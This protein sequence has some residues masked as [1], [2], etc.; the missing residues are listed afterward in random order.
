MSLFDRKFWIISAHAIII[1]LAWFSPLLF[2]WLVILAAMILYY[3]QILIIG[4]CVLTKWQFN[5]KTREETFY[6]YVLAKVGINYQNKYLGD[7]VLPWI[8]LGFAI[9]WQ[10]VLNHTPLI[11]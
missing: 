2:S 1:V 4:D 5:R 11:H 3:L 7:L 8:I 10:I 6:H 9:I